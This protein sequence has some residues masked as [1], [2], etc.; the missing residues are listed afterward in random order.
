MNN[1]YH[2]NYGTSSNGRSFKGNRRHYMDGLAKELPVYVLGLQ[3][4]AVLDNYDPSVCIGFS[5]NISKC[6]WNGRNYHIGFYV[7]GKSEGRPGVG[8]P[9]IVEMK[10]MVYSKEVC[11]SRAGD[12]ANCNIKYNADTGE[13]LECVFDEQYGNL[14]K[15]ERKGIEE[16]IS[17]VIHLFGEINCKKKQKI[18]ISSTKKNRRKH[19]DAK[20]INTESL[21]GSSTSSNYKNNKEKN[22]ESSTRNNI[23]KDNP[24]KTI[25]DSNTKNNTTSDSVP[26]YTKKYWVRQNSYNTNSEYTESCICCR[27]CLI[28]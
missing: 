10:V 16:F 8:F 19:L 27:H 22:H 20:Q 9:K 18:L 3:K 26:H 14:G 6:D 1:E 7:V 4:N 24:D 15:N 5:D 21:D 2:V 11:F 25:N 23:P 12:I 17:N 28:N 13:I